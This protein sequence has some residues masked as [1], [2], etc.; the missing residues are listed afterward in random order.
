VLIYVNGEL[1]ADRFPYDLRG[2]TT[3]ELPPA[4][5]FFGDASAAFARPRQR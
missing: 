4:R 2:L 1:L 5:H 3:S